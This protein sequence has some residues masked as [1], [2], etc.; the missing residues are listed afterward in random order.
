MLVCCVCRQSGSAPQHTCDS[1]NRP[2]DVFCGHDVLDDNGEALEG[3]GQPRL[4]F[5]CEPESVDYKCT[6]KRCSPPSK[7]S[8]EI[9]STTLSK[10]ED[11]PRKRSL[12]GL[13]SQQKD[14]KAA[15]QLLEKGPTAENL[16]EVLEPIADHSLSRPRS[17]PIPYPPLLLQLST[18]LLVFGPRLRMGLPNQRHRNFSTTI[19]MIW[20]IW[21]INPV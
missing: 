5:N 9:P 21:N 11:R 13:F 2:V 10:P 8:T 18:R 20:K 7:T 6:C 17:V 15:A 12:I 3:F 16:V 1:C 4:C 19:S 14:R